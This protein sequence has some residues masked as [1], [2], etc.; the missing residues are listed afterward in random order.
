LLFILLSIGQLNSND[1]LL[2]SLAQMFENKK[3]SVNDPFYQAMLMRCIRDNSECHIN[4]LPWKKWAP[5]YFTAMQDI[6]THGSNSLRNSLKSKEIGTNLRHFIV[7]MTVTNKQC[8][9]NEIFNFHD[10][11][12]FID[13]HPLY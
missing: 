2:E 1:W 6:M 13:V 11:L 5:V 9:F 3:L 8:T 10:N 12:N 4:H 7:V